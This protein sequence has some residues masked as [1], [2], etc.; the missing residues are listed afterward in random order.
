MTLGVTSGIACYRACDVVREL[1]R[2]GFRVR[3]V[4]TAN[5]T[6]FVAPDL[7]A[8]LSG[9]PVGTSTFEAGGL[10]GRYARYP[11]LFYARDIAAF[12]VAPATYDLIGRLAA[13]I[14]DDLLT[15]ALAATDAPIL[16]FPAMNAGMY[17]NPAVR[18]N[19]ERLRSRGV[20]IVEPEAGE[21]ACGDEGEGRLP[22]V[23]R[24]CAAVEAAARRG[25]QLRSWNV[26]VTAGPTREAIDPIRFLSN[27]STGTMG[28]ALAAEAARRGARVVLISGPTHLGAPPGVRVIAA[29]THAEM[30]DA[31]LANFSS[32]DAVIMAAAVGDYR[33]ARVEASK[34]RRRDAGWVL[35]LE[36]TEDILREV[37]LRRDEGT[38]LVGFA[39]EIDDPEENA[40][41]K[42]RAKGL[43]WIVVNNPL[44]PGA[45]F[46]AAT[47]RVTLLGRDGER[48]RFPVLAKTE[49]ARLL[50]DRFAA[51][52]VQTLPS[53]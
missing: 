50:W 34:I 13:G 46:G 31:V 36:R 6:R 35:S 10:S 18:E 30:R 8:A 14:A 37:S 19:L 51:R 9:E 1:R 38:L 44:E 27:P 29:T 7:F 41:A 23:E 5:A 28:Y 52:R 40:L 48:V 33:A 22:S 24:I 2:R 26:L 32:M 25:S 11:H 43:D 53:H 45:G 4:M 15:T 16:L 12:A 47:N 39:L 21:L 49:L 17:G 3:V 20:E 42:L